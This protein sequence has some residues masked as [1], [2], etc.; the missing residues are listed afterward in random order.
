MNVR[1]EGDNSRL[2][3]QRVDLLD[4]Q[5]YVKPGCGKID[6]HQFDRFR[7]SGC[8]KLGRIRYHL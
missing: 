2:R 1:T 6:D 4:Y 3:I 8:Q 5:I 7:F